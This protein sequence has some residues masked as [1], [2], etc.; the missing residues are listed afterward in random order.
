MAARIV[1]FDLGNVI[2][3]WEPARLYRR[4]FGDPEKADWF[5]REVCTLAWHTEHDRG[6]PMDENMA[7]LIARHPELEEHIRAW[8]SEWLDMFHGYVAGMPPLVGALEEARVPLFGLSNLPDAVAD[9]TFDAFPLIKLLR[10]VVVSGAEGVVKPD[11]HI[12]EIAL[13]RMGNPDPADVLFID[14]RPNNIEA[15]QALGLQGHVFDGV[16]GLKERLIV[17]GFLEN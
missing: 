6:V 8:K 1:L 14:D 3:D 4:R 16:E 2:V 12:Y 10:D 9:L 7:P 17:E 11:R 15:A 13:A 5:C